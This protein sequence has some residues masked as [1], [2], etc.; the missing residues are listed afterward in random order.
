MVHKVPSVA[1]LYLKRFK[2]YADNV[3]KLDSFRSCVGGF[4]QIHEKKNEEYDNDCT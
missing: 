3:H 1:A 4:L 2:G